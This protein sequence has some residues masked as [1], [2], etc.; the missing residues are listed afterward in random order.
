MNEDLQQEQLLAT[1][2]QEETPSQDVSSPAEEEQVKAIIKEV[3]AD[4]ARWQDDFDRMKKNREF[5][6]GFQWQDQPDLEDSELRRYLNNFV[7]N[8]VNQK[9]ATFYARNPKATF[10]RRPRLDFELW[11]G[12]IE[13][14]AQAVNAVGAFRAGMAP[15]PD[16]GAMALLQDFNDGRARQQEVKKVGTTLEMLY[17]WNVDQQEPEFKKQMKSLVRRTC[18]CGVGYV[19]LEA[20]R[21][22]ETT[23]DVPFTVSD[24]RVRASMV[25]GLIDE[26]EKGEGEEDLKIAE[27]KTTLMSM[28][29]SLATGEAEDT[30]ERL[31]FSFPK[32]SS[33]IPDRNCTCLKDFVGAD[34]VTEE[35]LLPLSFVKDYYEIRDLDAESAELVFYNGEGEEFTNIDPPTGDQDSARDQRLVCVWEVFDKKTKTRCTVMNGWKKFLISPEPVTPPTHRFWRHFA[36]TFNDTEYESGDKGSIFP[37]SD[38]DLARSAQREYNRSREALREHRKANEPR[39]GAKEGALNSKEIEKLKNCSPHDVIKLALGDQQK[40]SDVLQPIPKVPIDEAEY[41]TEHLERDVELGIG[42]QQANIGPAEANVTATVG[43]IAEQSRMTRAGSNV[44]DLDDLLSDLARSGGEILLLFTSKQTVIEVV[45][46]GSLWPEGPAVRGFL[47]EIFLQVQAASSG[48]PNKG[49]EMANLR[50]IVPL[51]IQ[52]GANPQFLVEEML[53]R[54]DDRLDISRAFP[55]ASQLPPMAMQGQTGQPTPQGPGQGQRQPAPRPNR[56]GVDNKPRQTAPPARA[57]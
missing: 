22:G 2:A 16:M 31:V 24:L 40:V 23:P 42:L 46:I 45:G 37:P 43:S 28:M 38:V 36:L 3:K 21:E 11:D 52:A 12:S 34:R 47:N 29:Y 41:T 49:V 25:Q 8:A 9:V 35:R 5:A 18:A 32:A 10:Q 44:D 20:V 4:K 54:W 27:L 30:K 19:R 33:V 57:Q 1:P 39:W 6:Y 50:E 51:L 53:T 14:L 55:L 17:Q 13:S 7:L 26:L 56:P 15:L 48:R